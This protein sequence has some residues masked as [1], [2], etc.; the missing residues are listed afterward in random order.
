MAFVGVVMM[1]LVAVAFCHGFVVGVTRV[2]ATHHLPILLVEAAV[3]CLG[4][5]VVWGAT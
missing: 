2:D 1:V 4:L 3:L 5:W